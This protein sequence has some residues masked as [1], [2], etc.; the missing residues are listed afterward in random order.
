MCACVSATGHALPPAYIFPRVNFKDHMLHGAPNGSKGFANP[1]GWMNRDLFPQVLEHFISIMNVS[2]Q[3][4][5]LLIMDNH[6]SHVTLN[7]IDLARQSGLTILT[8]PPH[9]SHR[10]QPLDVSVFGPFKTYYNQRCTEYLLAHREKGITIYEVASISAIPFYKAFTIE[11]IQ[12]GPS[13]DAP[14]PSG[15]TPGPSGDTPGPSGPARATPGPAGVALGPAGASP[16]IIIVSPEAI[17][18]FSTAQPR[19]DGKTRAKNSNSLDEE[20][21]ADE[22]SNNDTDSELDVEK[23]PEKGDFIM[24]EFSSG[25]DKIHYV[26]KIISDV[27]QDGDFEV[28]FLKRSTKT[29][30][31]FFTEEICSVSPASVVFVLPPPKEHNGQTKRQ[32]TSFSF[33][34]T[35]NNLSVPH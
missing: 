6:D 30:N 14:G 3:N 2:L 5:G 12:A 20:D 25:K 15:D 23:D 9:C 17:K 26:G 34:C 28:Q 13:G 33:D 16:S 35:F 11:N 21:E 19:T 18:P 27:D 22:Q 7:V 29:G 31:F 8:F 1:S 32:Q 24:T 10:M 4:P